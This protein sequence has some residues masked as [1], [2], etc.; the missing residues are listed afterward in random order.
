[1]IQRRQPLKS[2][3]RKRNANGGGGGASG[4]SS[5]FSRIIGSLGYGLIMSLIPLSLTWLITHWAL[6]QKSPR[7][8][9]AE[10]WLVLLLAGFTGAWFAAS[11][12]LFGWTADREELIAQH[13]NE[14]SRERQEYV[15]LVAANESA[16]AVGRRGGV[17]GPRRD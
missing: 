14:L 1:M 9:S 5:N 11:A 16:S 3:S 6:A 17:M 4:S 7:R 2:H 12:M 10:D 8:G 13:R 15:A